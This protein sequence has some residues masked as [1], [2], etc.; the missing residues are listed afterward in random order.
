M[1]KVLKMVEIIFLAQW[2]VITWSAR[3]IYFRRFEWLTIYFLAIHSS[4]VFIDWSHHQMARLANFYD[5]Y[6]FWGYVA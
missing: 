6:C 2:S 5:N 4:R 1:G 3:S